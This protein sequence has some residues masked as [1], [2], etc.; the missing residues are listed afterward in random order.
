MQILEQAES[1]VPGSDQESDGSRTTDLRAATR[2]LIPHPST[3]IVGRQNELDKISYLLARPD[4]RIVTLTGPP[5]AVQTR[6][7]V[8]VAHRLQSS[9][10]DGTCWVELA[11][12]ADPADVGVTVTRALGVT[13]LRGESATETLRRYLAGKRL[14]LV[15]DNFE[16]VLEAAES[17]AELDR[18][19]LGLR[20]LITSREP[21]NL[22]SEHQ[23]RVAPLAVPPRSAAVTPSE[24]E[25]APAGASWRARRHDEPASRLA[26]RRRQ[27]S[28]RSV[29]GSTVCPW[30]SS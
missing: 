12:V 29:L 1:L 20:F 30:R 19:C 18:G 16:H 3:G 5:G 22:A 21:L 27:P 24:I 4:V 11:G 10:P 25:V 26:P 6:L 7:A 28:P 15:V 9:F 23:F 8:A 13:P 14:L 17:I 2:S